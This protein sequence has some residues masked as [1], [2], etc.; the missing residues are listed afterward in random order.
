MSRLSQRE[1]DEII[2]AYRD[3]GS[4]T[5]IGR[6][7]GISKAYVIYLARGLARRR[8][9]DIPSLD[10]EWPEVEQAQPRRPAIIVPRQVGSGRQSTAGYLKLM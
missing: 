6:R 8:L 5:A 7:Y 9:I 3:G 10:T 4:P 2:A 1:R